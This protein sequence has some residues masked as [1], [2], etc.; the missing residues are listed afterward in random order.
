MILLQGRH[1]YC[2][3]LQMGTMRL[4]GE[5]EPAST[6]GA[7][8]PEGWVPSS[9]LSLP[10]Y[11]RWP[12]PVPTLTSRRAGHPQSGTCS[13]HLSPVDSSLLLLTHCCCQD[14]ARSPR[15]DCRP[16]PWHALFSP[17]RFPSWSL[18]SG[19]PAP[20]PPSA[21]TSGVFSFPALGTRSR[22]KTYLSASLHLCC[23]PRPHRNCHCLSPG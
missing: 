14:A 3:T 4:R 13:P 1:D 9:P 11:W 19:D 23:C 21:V 6:L 15:L 10:G 20:R 16:L 18:P 7:G 5:K 12:P 17:V 22:A 2:P 8:L